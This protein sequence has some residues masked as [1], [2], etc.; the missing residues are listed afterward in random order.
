MELHDLGARFAPG[1]SVNI[2]ERAA[3]ETEMAR[4]QAEERLHR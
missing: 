1:P 2:E 4:R 3:L